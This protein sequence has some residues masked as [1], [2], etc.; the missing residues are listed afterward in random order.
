MRVDARPAAFRSVFLQGARQSVGRR[1]DQVT[2]RRAL[3]GVDEDL[4]RAIAL[5][6]PTN[7]NK[8]LYQASMKM[9]E[10]EGFEPSI[11]VSQYND[12][13]NRRLQPLGHPSATSGGFPRRMRRALLA[14]HGPPCQ[15]RVIGRRKSS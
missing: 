11:P 13:A 7:E 9:A 6:L 14:A 15:R 2:E 8:G 5:G 10:G 12:L 1:L 3:A 4:G